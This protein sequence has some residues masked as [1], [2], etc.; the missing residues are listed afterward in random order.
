MTTYNTGN[1]IGSAD[2]KDFYDNA[3]NLDLA[4]NGTGDVWLDR[5]GV[6][7][8]SIAGYNKDMQDRVDEAAASANEASTSEQNAL[9]SEQAAAASANLAGQYKDAAEATA[10]SYVIEMAKMA[11]S[12]INTQTLIVQLHG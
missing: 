2:P 7:R 10:A 11:T 6:S 4:I 9:A 12:V 8:K 5:L 1:P 3:E